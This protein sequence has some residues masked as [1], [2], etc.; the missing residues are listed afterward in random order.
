MSSV[1]FY[2]ALNLLL[3]LL[4]NKGFYLLLLISN[5]KILRRL[6]AERELTL[7][8]AEDIAFGEE[9]AA[10]HVADIQSETTPIPNARSRNTGYNLVPVTYLEY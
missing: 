9:L 3:N 6:L 2:S 1:L 4:L 7:K 8:K 5:M 10:K